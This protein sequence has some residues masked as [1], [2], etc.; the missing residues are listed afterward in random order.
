MCAG[1]D[2]QGRTAHAAPI[3]YDLGDDGTI[4]FNTGADTLKGRTLERTGYASL[5]VQDDR[6]PFSFVTVS[7]PV[8]LI[9]DLN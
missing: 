8:D 6:P 7:G 3:W 2:A 4:V 5:T 9:D 1:D